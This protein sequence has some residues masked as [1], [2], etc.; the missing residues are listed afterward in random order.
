[1]ATSSIHSGPASSRAAS[2]LGTLTWLLGVAVVVSIVHYV[3][4]VANFHDYPESTTIPNPSAFLIAAA[5]F[6]FTAAG[7][8][9]YLE[10]RN[11]PTRRSL[12][13]LGLYSGSGL[14]GFAHYSVAGA[15]SMPWWR[16]TH[17]VLDIACGLAI[18][19]FAVRAARRSSTA[20]ARAQR[21]PAR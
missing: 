3:D 1:M 4:N 7:V 18:L 2:D 12:L 21:S 14:I 19:A 20:A 16:Q 13:L 15:T 9:G 11:G 6:A 5:W 8:A 17:I 10:Y